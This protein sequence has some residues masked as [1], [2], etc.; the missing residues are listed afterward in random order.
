VDTVAQ[1]EASRALKVA[2]EALLADMLRAIQ[3]TGLPEEVALIFAERL[4]RLMQA[5]GLPI[6]VAMKEAFGG[7]SLDSLLG[8]LEAMGVLPPP[9][10]AEIRAALGRSAAGKSPTA[11]DRA[12]ALALVPATPLP[13][14]FEDPTE[15]LARVPAI[16]LPEHFDDA[17]EPIAAE[18]GAHTPERH[19]PT[20]QT[21]KATAAPEATARA[22]E[23]PAPTEQT[24][25]VTAAAKATARAPE[26]PAHLDEPEKATMRTVVKAAAALGIKLP[27]DR[28]RTAARMVEHVR[29]S[30]GRVPDRAAR[31]RGSIHRRPRASRAPRRAAHHS[32]AA[33]ARDGPPPSDDAPPA[34]ASHSPH[35]AIGGAR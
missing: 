25:N 32:A 18:G 13:E 3:E 35:G 19:A 5:S 28:L 10:L 17:P 16:A 6:G 2:A 30:A 12:M 31:V 29:R 4:E 27:I 7:K 1:W 8:V 34:V 21:E 9:A 33:L 22:P 11:R 15:A 14:H 23:G 20:E 24:E 26:G